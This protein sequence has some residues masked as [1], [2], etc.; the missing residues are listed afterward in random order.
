MKKLVLIIGLAL[1]CSAFALYEDVTLERFPDADAV[2]ARH[3]DFTKYRPDGTYYSRDEQWVKILTEKGRREESEI[4][5]RYNKRYG[6]A[7]LED[8]YV[9]AADGT[10]REIDIAAT[11]NESSDNSYA[12]MNIYDPMDRVIT[13]TI[14]G[15]K[16]GD[17]LHSVTVRDTHNPRIKDQFATTLMFAWECPILNQTVTIHAPAELPIAQHAIR[18]P[19]GN[20]FYFEEPQADGSVVHKWTCKESPQMFSEPS[21][22]PAYTQYQNLRVSTAKDWPTLSRWYWNLSVPHLEKTN[23]AI[24]NQVQAIGPDIAK[25]FKWVSQEIRYMGL[26]FEE[27]SPG[28]APHDVDVTFD[29]RYGVCRDKAGLLVAML[30]IAGFEAYPV[31]IHNGAKMDPQVPSPYFNHAIVAVRAPEDP[32]ANKDGYILMDPTNEAA[33][34][35]LPAYLS[36]R[37]YLVACPEGENLLTSQVPPAT[38]NAIQ[39]ASKGQLNE[40]GSLLMDTTVHF[41]GVNDNDYRMQLLRQSADDSR[42]MMER[43]VRGVAPGAELLACEIQP[44]DL[45]A[46]ELPLVVKLTYR[47]PESILF[48]ETRDELAVPLLSRNFGRV[49]WLLSGKTAL[50]T[51]Q[52]PLD[53]NSTAMTAETL[54]LQLGDVLGQPLALPETVNIEGGYAYRRAYTVENGVLKVN[55]ALAINQVEFLP[56]EYEPLREN[57]QKVEAAERAR[58]IFAKNTL[59]DAHVHTKL[60][61]VDYRFTSDYSWVVTNHVVKKILTYDGKKSSSELKYTFNPSWQNVE[62]ISATV[63]SP[64]GKIATV[65]EKEKNLFDCNW[66]AAAPRYSAT[67]ELVV[68]L[69][70]VEIGSTITYTTVSTVKD[71]PSPYHAIIYFDSYEPVDEISVRWGEHPDAVRTVQNVKRLKREPMQAP[72]ILWRDYRVLGMGNFANAAEKLLPLTEVKPLKLDPSRQMSIRQIRNWMAK[73]VRVIGPSLYE[74]P[75]AQQMTDP[76]VVLA[77]RYA[78]RT[79]YIRTLCALLKGD[80]YDAEIVFAAADGAENPKVRAFNTETFQNVKMFDLP[81]CRVRMGHF[82]GSPSGSGQQPEAFYAILGTENEYTPIETSPY[83]KC[84]CLNPKTGKLERVR[85]QQLHE[86]GEDVYEIFVRENGAVDVDFKHTTFGFGV[87][88]LRKKYREMLPEDRTRHFQQ[89]LGGLSQSAVATRELKTESKGFTAEL[90]FSAYVPEFATVADDTISISLPALAVNPFMLTGANREAP[91]GVNGFLNDT[92]RV[93]VTFPEGYTCIE[94]LPQE[95]LFANPMAPNE[96]W[97]QLTVETETDEQGRLVA[98]VSCRSFDTRACDLSRDYVA[99]LKDWGRIAS[100]RA[101][102]T[103]IVRKAK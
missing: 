95:Y 12:D 52:H 40:D 26:T 18:H 82:A 22:P 32:R 89:L 11:Q 101:N 33:R 59:A 10:R 61:Q 63:E 100:S 49:N 68:N 90:S 75:L 7:K 98:I 73:N 37:S 19:L 5:L 48:G 27:V 25:L 42:K 35:L 67:Q 65:G 92:T 96:T 56:T 45:R 76:E 79:D 16:V 55:R 30:R 43:I 41:K 97:L 54:E 64:D 70:S 77:E 87:G 50:P 94:H 46:T 4:S 88:G 17:V 57:L 53:A 86:D 80:G 84:T 21:M 81:L 29:N 38:D 93:R 71:A 44:T 9:I 14:P 23:A 66:A 2:V 58:P 91:L 99:L 6:T 85:Q 69:P 36:D 60:M 72:G 24:T 102:R 47:A 15:L 8:V 103:I 20:V 3:D 28:Y 78:N 39:I 31:L 13:V 51:R 34:D 83:E 62:L 74:V 1:T